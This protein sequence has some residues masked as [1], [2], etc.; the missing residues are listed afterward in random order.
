MNILT[1]I[2]TFIAW[3]RTSPVADVLPKD[4]T[5]TIQDDQSSPIEALSDAESDRRFL[6][7]VTSSLGDIVTMHFEASSQADATHLPRLANELT[8][9]AS[10]IR[11]RREGLTDDR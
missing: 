10:L 4:D 3:L 6:G 1:T 8:M 7:F 5:M 9:L 11:T 2:R